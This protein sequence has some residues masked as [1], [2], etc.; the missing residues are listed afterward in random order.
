MKILATLP[1]RMNSTKQ[2]DWELDFYSRP[3]ME[4]NGKKRWEL[5]ITTSQ[6]FSGSETFRW[7]KKC[8]AGEV[9]SL[10]LSSALQEALEASK[11]D[12]WDF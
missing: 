7:E 10:W 11:K 1:N 8:P 6:D 3:I 9:N 5:L 2:A 4:P 12:G